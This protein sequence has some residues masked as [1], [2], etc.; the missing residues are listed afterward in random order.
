MCLHGYWRSS[1]AYRVRIALNLK[2]IEWM[3]R[4]VSLV[5][6]GGEHL[7]PTFAAL[8]PQQL[9]P[10]LSIDG[11]NLTQSLAIIEYLEETRPKPPL[12]PSDPVGRARV[13]AF[14]LA[15]A[16]E[17]HP[18]NNLRVLQHL[19]G[20]LGLSSEE[21]GRWY[22]HWVAGGLAA[23]EAMLANDARTGMFCEGDLPTLADICLVPQL[24]NARRFNV[25]LSPY[26]NTGAD[27]R[28]RALSLHGGRQPD[29]RCELA[30][31]R[32]MDSALTPLSIPVVA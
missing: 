15:V 9:V 13:R 32:R 29:H 7:Q 18:I 10:V 27:W 25:D 14:A 8:N 6:G 24:Y 23:L 1:A 26:P 11:A 17:I 3:H 12:I 2:G 5:Q 22:V 19:T 20:E 4:G 31:G 28:L 16:C 21:R 30:G